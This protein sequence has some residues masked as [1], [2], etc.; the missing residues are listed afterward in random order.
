MRV[1]D[2]LRHKGS[3]V[4]TVASSATLEEV[5]AI[6]GRERIGALVVTDDGTSV[7]GIVSER[8][9][10]GHL[11]A[12]GRD[13]LD[14]AVDTIMT[15]EVCTC[16]P[17]DAI[18]DLM[19]TMTNGRFRHVPVVVDGALGG[20]VSIGDLVARRLDELETESALRHDYIQTGRG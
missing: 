7:M 14:A 13:G 8:D 20:I 4:T 12:A 15:R 3:T 11:A 18:E 9:V 19:T 5:V 17:E 16:A 10:V 1:A 6:L 2:I